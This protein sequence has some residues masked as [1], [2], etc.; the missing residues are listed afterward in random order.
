[1][2]DSVDC[3]YCGSKNDMSD[4]LVGLSPSDNAFDHECG[5]C[6]QEFEVEVEFDPRFSVGKIVYEKCEKCGTETRDIC[7][8][9]RIF[10]YPK[11]LTETKIC[12]S[13]FKKAMAKEFEMEDAT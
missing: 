8:K 7:E 13:C 3:P 12:L 10:P 1:M 9:G 2:F 6:E 4:A 5:N 11:H